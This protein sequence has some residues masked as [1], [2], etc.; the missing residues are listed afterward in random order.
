MHP[1]IRI[2]LVLML[3]LFLL[4]CALEYYAAKLADLFQQ[5]KGKLCKRSS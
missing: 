2:I 4:G 3:A 1:A 5:L